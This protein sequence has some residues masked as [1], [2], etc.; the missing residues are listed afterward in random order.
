MNL[1]SLV[2]RRHQGDMTE[3][4]KFVHGIYKSGHTLLLMAPSSALRGHIYKL[5]KRH[6]YTQLRSNFFSFIV[7][8][9]WNSLPMMLYQLRQW[10][11]WML[12][13]K[14]W[15]SIG[16]STALHWILKIIDDNKWSAKRLLGLMPRAEDKGKC[17]AVVISYNSVRAQHYT[18]VGKAKACEH[19][20][21]TN[22][23]A[24]QTKNVVK[25]ASL[26]RETITLQC[27][28]STTDDVQVDWRIYWNDDVLRRRH[29]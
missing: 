9:L 26:M 14:G 12:S 8:N 29:D 4:Y 6:C 18:Q 15:T 23:Q 28:R 24:D 16:R 17:K 20:V 7:V 10:N 11:E 1:P 25:H 3:V 19:V 5:K 21:C 22:L 13:G 2:Y 27:L